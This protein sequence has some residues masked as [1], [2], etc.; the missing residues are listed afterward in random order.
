[1]SEGLTMTLAAFAAFFATVFFMGSGIIDFSTFFA[2]LALMTSDPSWTK[3][4]QNRYVVRMG[5]RFVHHHRL[6]TSY[7]LIIFRYK[8][9]SSSFDIIQ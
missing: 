2:T 4:K 7:L 9:G 5:L 8:T 1:M 3:R 6:K